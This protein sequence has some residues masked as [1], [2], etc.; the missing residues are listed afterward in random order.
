MTLCSLFPLNFRGVEVRFSVGM[1]KEYYLLTFS[2]SR[3]GIYRKSSVEFRNIRIF[4]N[5]A[6]SPTFPSQ[7]IQYKH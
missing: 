4:E 3:S 5:I 6:E 2:F 1:G 7:L